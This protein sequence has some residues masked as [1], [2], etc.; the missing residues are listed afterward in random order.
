MILSRNIPLNAYAFLSNIQRDFYAQLF[1]SNYRGL[2]IGETKRRYPGLVEGLA[3]L[4]HGRTNKGQVRVLADADHII[5]TSLWNILIPLV[6]NLSGTPPTT[7]D[8]LSNLFWRTVSFNRGSETRGEALD[9]PWIRQIKNEAKSKTSRQWAQRH[10]EMFLRTK[11]DEGV[12]VDVPVDPGRINEM[13]R[14]CD[15][16]DV[17]EFIQ[18]ARQTRPQISSGELV[19]LV[20]NRFPHIRIETEGKVPRVEMG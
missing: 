3:D 16:G 1:S 5:P 4:G 18:K 7:P 10:V 11:H 14:G 15:L 20:E 6:W 13:S 9:Q 2:L 8:I 19:D 17:I 12:N